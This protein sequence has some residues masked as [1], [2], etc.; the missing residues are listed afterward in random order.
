MYS[1][2]ITHYSPDRSLYYDDIY[3]VPNY[4]ELNSRSEADTSVTFGNKKFNLPIIPSNMRGTIDEKWA[5]WLSENDYFYVMHRFDAGT[6][7][8]V[9]RANYQEWKNIS[10][11]TGVNDESLEELCLINVK[12]FRIDYIT[13]DVAHGHH[14]KVKKRIEEIKRIFP[15]VFLIAGNTSTPESTTD[16]ENWGADATKCLI[17]TGSACSTKYQTGFHVPSFSCVQSC[18]SVAKKPIIADGGAKHYGDIAKSLVSGATMVMSGG[19]FASCNDSPAPTTDDGKKRYFGN[20]S[21]V[22]KGKNLHVEGFDLQIEDSGIS[23]EERLNEIKQALQS[24][25]SY[26]GGVDLS[27]FN[28]TKYV[29]IK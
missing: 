16:L 6:V 2:N 12:G 11:S 13:I 18:A 5:K 4:S 19:M 8:F 26:A 28:N 7:P 9:E 24:S 10:I 21:A 1:Y 25:I 23:L 22:A 14:F 3:L 20:A 17:G 15:D 27:C 29:T